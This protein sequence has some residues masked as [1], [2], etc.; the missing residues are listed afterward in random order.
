MILHDK[1]KAHFHQ[2]SISTDKITG[3]V[4]S[5]SFAENGIELTVT[6]KS[7][8]GRR[9]SFDYY[10]LAWLSAD[11][12][13]DLGPFSFHAENKENTQTAMYKGHNYLNRYL[14]LSGLGSYEL[15]YGRMIYSTSMSY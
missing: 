4:D 9:E 12:G 2:K 5:I 13:F 8:T 1:I 11:N 15:L 14:D 10:I 7:T 6:I 3:T